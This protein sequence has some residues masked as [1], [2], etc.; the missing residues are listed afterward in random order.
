MESTLGRS[1]W[2][3]THQVNVAIVPSEYERQEVARYRPWIAGG[4]PFLSLTEIIDPPNNITPHGTVDLDRD[5]DH[6][7]KFLRA[8]SA[9]EDQWTSALT[10]A[11]SRWQSW[12][13]S[14]PG[15]HKP[16][17]LV[18]RGVEGAG[19][20]KTLPELMEVLA[21]KTAGAQPNNSAPQPTQ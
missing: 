12:V 1:P 18:F 6:H 7:C 20:S 9:S 19:E 3:N 13:T 4:V 11:R 10:L 14:E 15:F 5:C 16:G 8:F 21:R 2:P 17:K